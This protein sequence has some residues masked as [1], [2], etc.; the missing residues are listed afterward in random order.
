MLTP[1]A[2]MMNYCV[3]TATQAFTPPAKFSGDDEHGPEHAGHGHAV[4]TVAA[5]ADARPG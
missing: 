1:Q 3:P 4:T 2:K 5:S